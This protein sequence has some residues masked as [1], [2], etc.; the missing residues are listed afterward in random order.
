MAEVQKIDI[1]LVKQNWKY[2]AWKLQFSEKK[3]VG[4]VSF[5]VQ[6]YQN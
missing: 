3:P 5:E 2:M 6:E 4:E 1:E